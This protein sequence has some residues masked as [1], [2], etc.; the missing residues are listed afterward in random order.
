MRILQS[1]RQQLVYYSFH[2]GRNSTRLNSFQRQLQKQVIFFHKNDD[3][4][5]EHKQSRRSSVSTS[6]ILLI[7]SSGFSAS[8]DMNKYIK[9]KPL[10]PLSTYVPPVLVAQEQLQGLRLELSDPDLTVD[11]KS[12]RSMLRSGSF[13]GL[14]TDI[15]AII[16][17]AQED[18][19]IG[20][21]GTE[22]AKKF[23][24]PLERMDTKLLAYARSGENVGK[25]IED[26]L[27]MATEGLNGIL[28]TLPRS[29]LEKA[30]EVVDQR[31][32]VPVTTEER[33]KF[34][35]SILQ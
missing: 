29:V 21:N 1:Q 26:D 6:L 30:S 31:K 25:D 33:D 11:P 13:S 14:R 19:R 7:T 9:S 22:L 28:A 23:L 27:K 18:G 24:G 32:P 8:A 4:L 5:Q 35:E 3:Q 34:L 16:Q 15:R 10:D 2:K 20:D 12:V 17:Y